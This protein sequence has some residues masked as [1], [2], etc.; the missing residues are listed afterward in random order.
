MIDPPIRP[1]L[2]SLADTIPAGMMYEPK[3]DG[4]RC[5][6]FVRDGVVR[7]FSRRGTELTSDF[8]ELV[9][10]A[11]A[12]LP[13]TCVVDGEII[14]LVGNRLEYSALARR[15]AAGGRAARLAR[16]I[17]ASYVVF[18]VL[19]VGDRDCRA[20]AQRVRRELLEQ[21]MA[22]TTAPLILTPCTDDLTTAERW[23]DDLEAYGLDGL[24]A[25][26]PHQPYLAGSR[27]LTKIKHR[28]TAD[29]VVGGY[30][31]DRNASTR[32]PTLGSLLLGAFTDDAQLHFLGVSAG[33]PQDTRIELG[34]MLGDL[35][36]PPD[37]PS[38]PWGRGH[39]DGRLPDSAVGWGR[40]QQQT[41]LIEPLLACEV[42][43]DA[44]H[45]D[46]A[47]V[48]FRSNASFLRWRPD[49]DALDCRLDTLVRES[50]GQPAKLQDWLLGESGPPTDPTGGTP[51]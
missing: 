19:W 16:E 32:V 33:F 51:Q 31:W 17:P 37:S 47:G 7:L 39:A 35:E 5:L 21:L 44:L 30:R 45:P 9:A 6:C 46:P 28:R 12:Q 15:H 22:G 50:P 3:W 27:A 11:G 14:V 13:D 1:M 49:K 23:F 26:P 4:W 40:H 36:V 10:A 8:P 48:R 43:Y 20:A 24:V 38:H 42:T 2:A 34:R 25:K 41:R 29:V 18:D